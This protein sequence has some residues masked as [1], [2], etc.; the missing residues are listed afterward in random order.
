M[1]GS[2]VK[3]SNPIILALV[4]IL[5]LSAACSTTPV[6]VGGPGGTDGGP[7]SI[8]TAV[9]TRTITKTP[10]ISPT[11]TVTSTPTFTPTPMPPPDLELLDVTVYPNTYNVVGQS[12]ALMGRIRNNTNTTML[13]YNDKKAFSFTVESWEYDEQKKL[14]EDAEYI[15]AIY[16]FD[17]KVGWDHKNMNCILYPGEEGVIAFRFSNLGHVNMKTY[18]QTPKYTG[19]LGVWYTYTSSYDTKPDLPA[20]FHYKA[21]NLTFQD[22]DGA[23]VFDFDLFI[24]NDHLYPDWNYLHPTWVIFYDKDGKIIDILQKDL[25]HY[26][27]G[28]YVGKTLHIHTSTGYTNQQPEYF[29]PTIKLTSEIAAQV[30]HFEVLS[31]LNEEPVCTRVLQK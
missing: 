8:P 25:V 17:L 19:S 27:P 4:G 30:D 23:I 7:S 29:D 10:T 26:Y 31:E 1:I 6:T 14:N 5:L 11:P 15:H 13:L 24:P 9:Y 12:Y 28:Y 20:R 22:K 18:D 3:K 2:N 16:Q 21:E